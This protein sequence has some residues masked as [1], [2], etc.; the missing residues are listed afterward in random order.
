MM[1]M[2]NQ[3]TVMCEPSAKKLANIS[4]ASSKSGQDATR[5]TFIPQIGGIKGILEAGVNK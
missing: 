5:E 4:E 2:W 1:H 3:I